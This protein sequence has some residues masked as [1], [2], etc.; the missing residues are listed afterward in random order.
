M[1]RFEE[2]NKALCQAFMFY[3]TC[4]SIGNEIARELLLEKCVCHCI[5]DIYNF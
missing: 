1:L 3:T 5:N 4:K 2:K